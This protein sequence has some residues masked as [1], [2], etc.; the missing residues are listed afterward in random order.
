[1]RLTF[2][3]G[4]TTVLALLA[5]A[6]TLR[7]DKVIPRPFG[8]KVVEAHGYVMPADS[9]SAPKVIPVDESKLKRIPAGRPKVVATNT[10][11]HP[12]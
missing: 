3:A 12:V 6:C 8:P 4:W 7:E 1:M 9:F 11:I 10:N 2:I 5:S